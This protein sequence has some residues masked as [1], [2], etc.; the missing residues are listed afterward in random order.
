MNGAKPVVIAATA[1]LLSTSA[2]ADD[3]MSG[4]KMYKCGDEEMKLTQLDDG[5]LALDGKGLTGYVSVH[6][7][8]GMYRGSVDGWGSQHKTPKDALDAACG[9][10]LRKAQTL[11]EEALKKRLREFYEDWE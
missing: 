5:R 10:L 4:A 6:P 7:A 11:S 2:P 1:I 3:Q 8:T 9:W